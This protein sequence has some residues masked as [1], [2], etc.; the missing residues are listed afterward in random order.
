MRD[1]GWL[2]GWTKKVGVTLTFALLL[3]IP[4]PG[5]LVVNGNLTVTYGVGG[6]GYWPEGTVVPW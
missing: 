4:H 2:T 6:N 3:F 5:H 1:L